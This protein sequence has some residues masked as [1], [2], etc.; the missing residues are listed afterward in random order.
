MKTGTITFLADRFGFIHESGTN[1]SYFLFWASMIGGRE[2]WATINEG[3]TIS[4]DVMPDAAHPTDRAI[5]VRV[6]HA[7]L[8]AGTVQPR[9]PPRSS[10]PLPVDNPVST[11]QGDRQ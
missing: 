2:S 7:R 3:D 5:N 6:T 4:F 1:Q 9:R 8:P 10:Y 11:T